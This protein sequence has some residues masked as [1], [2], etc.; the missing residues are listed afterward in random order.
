MTSS[1]SSVVPAPISV[2]ENYDLWDGK[3]RTHLRSQTLWQVVENGSNP[4]PLPNNPAVAQLRFHTEEMAKEG[5]ALAIIHVTVHNDVFIKILNLKTT[6]EAWDKLKEEFQG[7]ERTRRMKVL[8]L[9][10]EFEVIKM[11]EFE[12][13]KEYSDRLFKVVTKIRL[14]GEELKDQR[15]VENFF[16]LDLIEPLSKEDH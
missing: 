3:M 13:V 4:T 5:R 11:K 12:I 7:S 2:G 10:R 1:N 16:F 6:K 9:I 15:V 8:N 14:L